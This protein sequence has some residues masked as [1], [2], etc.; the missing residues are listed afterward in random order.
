MEPAWRHPKT[1]MSL[2]LMQ[3]PVQHFSDRSKVN[4]YRVISNEKYKHTHDD[5]HSYS[6]LSHVKHPCRSGSK[7]RNLQTSGTNWTRSVSHAGLCKRCSLHSSSTRQLKK[8]GY[9]N[10]PR[11]GLLYHKRNI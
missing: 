5:I 10:H 1:P 9:I 8:R 3:I 6:F 2:H 7:H 11:R 4:R